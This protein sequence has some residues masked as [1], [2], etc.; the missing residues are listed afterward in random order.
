MTLVPWPA[1]IPESIGTIGSTQGVKASSNP[2]PKKEMMTMNRLPLRI[3][4]ASRSWADTKTPL[5][6]AG[7]AAMAATLPPLP[8][9]SETAMVR[10]IGT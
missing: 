9:G 3:R 10:V 6:A 7:A 1:M 4:A 8:G 2:E 5:L